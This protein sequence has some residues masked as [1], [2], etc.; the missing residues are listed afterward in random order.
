MET[1]SKGSESIDIMDT[2]RLKFMDFLYFLLR[3]I[4]SKLL[5]VSF[6]V[7]LSTIHLALHAGVEKEY[8]ENLGQTHYSYTKDGCTFKLISFD[9]DSINSKVLNVRRSCSFGAVEQAGLFGVLFSEMK[10][11]GKVEKINRISWGAISD[12]EIIARLA[13]A[14]VNSSRWSVIT[15]D[16]TKTRLAKNIPEVVNIL[17]ESLVFQEL[18]NISMVGYQLNVKSTEGV[19]VDRAEKVDE[20]SG[21]NLPKGSVVPFTTNVW[22]AISPLKQQ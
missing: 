22:F 21:L 8:I 4:D 20:L 5:A 18:V 7:F 16:N 12:K 14:A 10:L 2:T 3:K 6:F 1:E 11:D 9:A 19:L 17:N 15:E 13:V